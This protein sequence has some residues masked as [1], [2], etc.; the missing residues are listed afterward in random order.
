M[1]VEMVHIGKTANT[2]FNPHSESEPGDLHNRYLLPHSNFMQKRKYINTWFWYS[3]YWYIVKLYKPSIQ[4]YHVMNKHGQW[5]SA[6]KSC[7]LNRPS[8]IL[9]KEPH[10]GRER[11][12]YTCT[13]LLKASYSA[14]KLDSFSKNP[15]IELDLFSQCLLKRLNSKPL[16]Q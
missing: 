9:W 8:D 2:R 12:S 3:S 15:Y 4:I 7:S 6:K 16:Q 1:P 13:H 11:L 14:D 10:T 5:K